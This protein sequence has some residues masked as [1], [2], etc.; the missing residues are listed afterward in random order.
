MTITMGDVYKYIS[1]LIII[2]ETFFP[3]YYLLPR[4]PSQNFSKVEEFFVSQNSKITIC[5]IEL[6]KPKKVKLSLPIQSLLKT[7]MICFLKKHLNCF[8]ASL[9]ASDPSENLLVIL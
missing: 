5:N 9:R 7:C 8:D 2:R 4:A 3:W 1:K 6:V